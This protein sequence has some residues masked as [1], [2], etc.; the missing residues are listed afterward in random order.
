MMCQL[1]DTTHESRVSH[2]LGT[3]TFRVGTPP[4]QES[5]DCDVTWL[6]LKL[7]HKSVDNDPSRLELSGRCR[8]ADRP[9]SLDK[10]R[11]FY[12]PVLKP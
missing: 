11:Q 5:A 10:S 9:L 4:L 2:L 1:L 6:S 8:G 7:S 12:N 3:A